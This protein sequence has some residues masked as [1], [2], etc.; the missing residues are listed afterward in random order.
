MGCQS[1]GLWSELLMHR[2]SSG[3]NM[4]STEALSQVRLKG[5][6]ILPAPN[7]HTSSQRID[8]HTSG[9]SVQ[10]SRGDM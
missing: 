4:P 9:A 5:G 2:V 3:Q 6:F 7:L 1:Q 8:E 10:S